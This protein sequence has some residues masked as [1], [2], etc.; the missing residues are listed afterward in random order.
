MRLKIT[1]YVV[2]SV[3]RNVADHLDQSDESSGPIVIDYS[4]KRSLPITIPDYTTV[5]HAG[6]RY[7]VSISHEL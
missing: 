2:I 6:E 1:F 5:H 4:E 7:V 3:P